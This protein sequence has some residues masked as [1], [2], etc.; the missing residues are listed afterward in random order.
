MS[1]CSIDDW[2]GRIGDIGAIYPFPRSEMTLFLV[3]LVVWPGWH[4]TILRRENRE[5][6]TGETDRHDGASTSDKAD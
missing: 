5:L 1:T 2:S 4:F 6:R 3:A